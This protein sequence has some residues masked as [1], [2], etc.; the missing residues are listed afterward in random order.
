M[1]KS[2]KNCSQSFEITPDDL[3]FYAK[4]GVPSPTRCWRCRAMRRMAWRNMT[5]LYKRTC[6]ATG[7][8][9]YTDMTP[10][11]PM[12]VYDTQY[13][14]S[15]AWDPMSYGRDYDS[16]RGFFEQWQE[17]YH[18]VPWTPIW[19]YGKVN[20][21]YSI[22]AFIKNCYLCF[23]TG[24]NTE[25]CAYCVSVQF[26]KQSFNLVN[27]KHCELC[28][29]CINTDN[30]YKTFFSRNCVSCTDSWFLQDCVG[31]T[32]CFGCTGLRNKS[33]C[34]F[35]EQY[36]KEEYKKKLE[37][38]LGDFKNAKKQALETWL[39]YPVKSMHGFQN[40]NVTGDYIFN[41]A[42]LRMC[43]FA[44]GAQHCIYS[45]SIIYVPVKD[46][47][48]LTSVGDGAELSYEV[49]CAG[50]QM[51]NLAFANEC[52]TVRDSQYV[53][54]CRQSSDLFGC[55]ALKN[56]KYCILNK[57]YSPDE[58]KKLRSQII[59]DMKKRGEYGEF[60]PAEMSPW[61]YNE[62]Q[63]QDYFT[64]S[65]AEA[66]SKGFR[67]RDQ[68]RKEVQI[69]GDVIAYEHSQNCD[70]LCSGGFKMIPR[71]AEFI[72]RM[73]LPKPTLCFNCRYKELVSWRN[74]PAFYQRECAKC[75]KEIETSYAPD[76]WY[77]TWWLN[78][79]FSLPELK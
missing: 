8:T 36:S 10:L 72:E 53:M 7:K 43:F 69:G 29:F 39:K 57:Q 55:V 58:Y 23:D 74:P 73:R 68:E 67:W 41:S 50:E 51:A 4:I 14:F 79:N 64:L 21:E 44:N 17:L 34:I 62:T 65:K 6:D 61:G 30:S 20:S 56:K 37:G 31:C 5:H 59:A 1:Q 76:K 25:D 49:L 40:K 12:P 11:A 33:Y 38:L 18:I 2:C 60:F 24:N 63:A 71:E 46:S 54:N 42:D 32:S 45:Q 77:K 78:P 16:N 66:K 9:I 47:M 19:N 27:S 70:H 22:G 3:S 15:D 28:Y 35:N 75:G 13:F 48:D 52:I 26:G